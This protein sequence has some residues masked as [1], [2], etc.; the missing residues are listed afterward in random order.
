MGVGLALEKEAY[1]RRGKTHR[2]QIELGK[3]CC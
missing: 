3:D 1:G 2:G